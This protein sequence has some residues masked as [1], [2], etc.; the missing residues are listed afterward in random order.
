[1]LDDRAPILVVVGD[2]YIFGELDESGNVAR[3][4]RDFDINSSDDLQDLMMVQPELFDQYYNLGLSYL[5]VGTA[6]ALTSLMPLLYDQENR[7]SVRTMS[8]LNA[9]DLTGNHVIYVGYISG[10]GILQNLMFSASHLNIGVT[11]DELYTDAGESYISD[12]GILNTREEFRDYG[13]VSA[14]TSPR[15][16]QYLLVAGMRDA[17]LI[18]MAE[19]I[20][21]NNGLQELLEKTGNGASAWE[22]LYGVF[23]Y[24]HTS[25]DA[26]LVYAGELDASNIWGGE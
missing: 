7:V 5:P 10:L 15:G 3:M 26:K 11:Y 22:G 25:F 20:S 12:S 8:Q 23:G 21:N 19:E 13:M 18:S 1:M 17:A 4:V 6:S 9:S 14:F 16:H 2:Y 24:D